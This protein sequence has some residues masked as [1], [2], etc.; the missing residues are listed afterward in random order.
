MS[1]EIFDDSLFRPWARNPLKTRTDVEQALKDLVLPVE[2]YRSKGGARIRLDS[3]AAHF[4]QASADFEGYSRLLWGLAPA[5][6][7]GANWIDWGPVARGLANGCDPDHPE[8]WGDTFDVSQRLVELAAIGF[9]LRLVPEKI[10]EPL[11]D[12]QRANVATYLIAGHGRKHADNNWK[13]FRLMVGMGLRHVGVDYDRSLDDTYIRDL[14]AFYLGDGWYHDGNTRRADHYVPFALHFYGL[15]L[16]ALDGGDW[17]KGYRE[18]ASLIARDMSRWFADDGAALCFGRS[19]TYRFAIAGFFGATALAGDK[20]IAWGQQK[21]FYLRNLRWWAKQPFAAR[22]GI[23]P[24]GYC[25]PNLIM[26]EPYNSAQSPYWA[27]KAF[28]PLMLPED[29]PFWASEEEACPPRPEAAIQRHAGFVIANPL[30]D[31]IALSSGQQTSSSNTFV[32]F[33]PEKYAKFAY[34][35]RYGFSIENDPW[36]FKN[37]V[38]DNM[39]GFSDDGVHFRVRE[40]N[41]Q[42]MVTDGGLLY[43]FWKP[44]AD[45]SVDTF[46]YWDGGYHVRLHRIETPRP[47]FTIEGGFAISRGDGVMTEAEG[48][49]VAVT[50]DDIS[51]VYDLSPSVRRQGRCHFAAPN[52]NLVSAKTIVPQ[53]TGEIPLGVTVLSIAVF[54]QAEGLAARH[55]LTQR[56]AAPDVEMLKARIVANGISVTLMHGIP[57]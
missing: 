27:F 48:S 9:A 30:G 28:L 34:S 40:D 4:D 51:A 25:Y 23:L 1:D 29:H 46:L 32:R 57:N 49:A 26:S 38:L 7:G 43:G 44:F 42:A 20:T 37:A 6:V 13:F 54:A 55:V 45:V 16:A 41:E 24:V 19:M 35:A 21:G 52:T 47:L 36:R 31:A 2:T 17:T 11:S 12:K 33:G 15:V 18:R 22:D 14:D 50:D 56:P 5:E 53:L 39:I 8:Y 3:A 10:W